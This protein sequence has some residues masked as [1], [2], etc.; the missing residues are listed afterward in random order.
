MVQQDKTWNNKTKPSLGT[1]VKTF[2]INT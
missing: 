1:I 2:A